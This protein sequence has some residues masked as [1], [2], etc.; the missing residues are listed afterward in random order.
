MLAISVWSW[1][2]C[3]LADNS[4]VSQNWRQEAAASGDGSRGCS[5]VKCSSSVPCPTE[6]SLRTACSS[7]RVWIRN[8]NMPYTTVGYYKHCEAAGS[9]NVLIEKWVLG[10]LYRR[11]T[12]RGHLKCDI[13]HDLIKNKVGERLLYFLAF[14]CPPFPPTF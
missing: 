9:Y 2:L 8:P 4:Y 3:P 12:C 13:V 10:G 5:V 14:T 1:L 6:R 11:K 7:R